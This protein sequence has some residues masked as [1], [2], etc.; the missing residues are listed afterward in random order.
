MVANAVLYLPHS[1]VYRE[2]DPV[3]RKVA[4]R[5]RA[6]SCVASSTMFAW[7]YAPMF[8]YYADLPAASRF[9]LMA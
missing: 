1:G 8:Y 2:R 7:G 4:R 9:A 3:F 5:L 6:D